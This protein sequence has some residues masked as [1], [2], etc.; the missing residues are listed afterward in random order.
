MDAMVT[1]ELRERVREDDCLYDQHAARLEATHRGQYVAIGRTGEIVVGLD[2]IWVLDQALAKF[3][4][5]IF[6]FRKIGEKTLGRWR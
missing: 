3:G 1:A 6:A 5:G 4:S 2:D